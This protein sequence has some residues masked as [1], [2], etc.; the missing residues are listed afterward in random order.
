MHWV[1]AVIGG[2]IRFVTFVGERHEHADTEE[3]MRIF[4]VCDHA[5]F[6]QKVWLQYIFDVPIL[7]RLHSGS[8][9]LLL[10]EIAWQ[11]IN[12][13]KLLMGNVIILSSVVC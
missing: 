3:N 6:R 11:Q 4:F 12:L 13:S 5:V 10:I 9:V 8:A 1:E 7:P 2:T